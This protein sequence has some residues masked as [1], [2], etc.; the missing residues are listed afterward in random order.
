MGLVDLLV[1]GGLVN[2]VPVLREQGTVLM[3][4]SSLALEL[5]ELLQLVVG[6]LL[7]LF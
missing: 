3:A 7:L 2:G 6:F 4:E 5:D 1:F